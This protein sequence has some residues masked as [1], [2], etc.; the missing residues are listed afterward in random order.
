MIMAKVNWLLQNWISYKVIKAMNNWNEYCFGS[1]WEDLHFVD[2]L[3]VWGWGGGWWAYCS[4]SGNRCWGWWWWWWLV[5]EIM[6]YKLPDTSINV[7]I[8]ACWRGQSTGNGTTWWNTCFGSI[9]WYWGWYWGGWWNDWWNWWNWWW[10]GGTYQSTTRYWWR[11]CPG[12]SPWAFNVNENYWWCW[13][14]W[15]SWLTSRTQACGANWYLSE[16]IWVWVWWWG[17]SSWWGWGCW[18]GG[19]TCQNAT[20]YWWWW[21]GSAYWWRTCWCD[22]YQWLVVVRYPN[23]WSY[24]IKCATGGTVSTCWDYTIHCF[25]SNWTFCIIS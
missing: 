22:W 24:W 14:W 5:K 15:N 8:W 20:F 9:I 17:G 7:V 4:S 1:W 16:I 3:V 6:F 25:T 18:W 12:W 13:W 11:W 19:W 23:D 21:G 2:V 10:A